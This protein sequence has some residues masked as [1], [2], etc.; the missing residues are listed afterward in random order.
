MD[1][2]DGLTIRVVSRLAEVPAAEWDACAGAENPFVGHAFLDALEESGSVSGKTGWLPRHLVRPDAPAGTRE[3]LIGGLL[4][5]ARRHRVSSLHVTFP[6]A[7]EWNELG[8]AGFLK[9]QGQQFHWHNRGYR[10]FDDFLD[11]LASRKRKQIKR[12]RRD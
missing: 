8:E 11:A 7:D 3:L 10:D 1:G 9:R 12:E 2:S 6:K 4:E 5:V